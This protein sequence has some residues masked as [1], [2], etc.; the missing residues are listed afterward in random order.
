MVV[1]PARRLLFEYSCA[2]YYD[3]DPL[4]AINVMLSVAAGKNSKNVAW[5][6]AYK[7]LELV[8]EFYPDQK[9]AVRD[10]LGNG[11]YPEPVSLED[12]L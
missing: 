1:S 6:L 8:G 9:K 5:S 10:A 11:R 7:A 4:A 3:N 2:R 12:D